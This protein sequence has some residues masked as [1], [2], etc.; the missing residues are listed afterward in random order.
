MDD[1]SCW[2]SLEL[3]GMTGP[4]TAFL[5]VSCL[6]AVTVH[7]PCGTQDL[8]LSLLR[9]HLHELLAQHRPGDC[10]ERTEVSTGK[11][12]HGPSVRSY[13]PTCSHQPIDHFQNFKMCA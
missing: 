12:G 9:N 8:R 1:G 6:E 13:C 3:W 4:E 11:D 10:R 5:K 7:T 2:C